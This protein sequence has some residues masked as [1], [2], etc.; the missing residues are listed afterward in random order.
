MS[1]RESEYI[2]VIGGGYSGDGL[3][4]VGGFCELSWTPLILTPLGVWWGHS[5]VHDVQC[6]VGKKKSA[7]WSQIPDLH[8]T[9]TGVHSPSRPHFKPSIRK[10]LKR[11]G[12]VIFFVCSH[13]QGILCTNLISKMHS[14]WSI[15]L[16]MLLTEL[17]FMAKPIFFLC[18]YLSKSDYVFSINSG[19]R[20][21]L[22]IH[23]I[24]KS[25]SR[26]QIWTFFLPFIKVELRQ[27]EHGKNIR[28][29]VVR[30]PRAGMRPFG[31]LKPSF[32]EVAAFNYVKGIIECNTL[33]L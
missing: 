8:Y 27:K 10:I 7:K 11:D 21:I 14:D 9:A 3:T 22:F 20:L 26:L 28:F 15:I 1:E 29:E 17:F 19:V 18:L 24:L 33:L 30:I 16:V 32:W 12:K 25:S 4:G 13:D 6:Q 5:S 31:I 2:V 23:H